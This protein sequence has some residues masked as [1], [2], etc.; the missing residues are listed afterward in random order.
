MTE[1]KNQIHIPITDFYGETT[2]WPVEDLVHCERLSLRSAKFN[3]QIKPHR[4]PDL[5]QMF[6]VIKGQGTAQ[7]D[8]RS[9]V[10][11]SGDLLV[12]PENCVHMFLW[13]TGSDGYVL[14]VARPLLKKLE[15]VLNNPSWTH[16]VA[17]VYSSGPDL[18]YLSSLLTSINDEH[19][20]SETY[21]QLQ[22]ENQVLSLAI[23]ITR[24]NALLNEVKKQSASRPEQRLKRFIDL[25]ESNFEKHHNVDWYAEKV[26][27]TS[28]HLNEICKK[29]RKQT[30]LSLIHQ[31]VLTEA[32]RHL[33]F[34]IKPASDIADSL[35]FSDPAYFSRFFKRL[36]GTTPKQFRDNK[37]TQ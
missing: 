12:I 7:I 22:M 29:L 37:I 18:E 34:T 35:G 32:Q 26:G 1:T 17:S 21:R 9:M 25:L 23:W 13:E 3:W 2:A 31:R 28:A 11:N 20:G 6:F 24:K 19:A 4:H 14:A 30:A 16:G 36:T 15:Q 27:I 33:I 5:V 10:V 8:N